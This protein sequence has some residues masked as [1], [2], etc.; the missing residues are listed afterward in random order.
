MPVPD[1]L[2]TA[3]AS[4]LDPDSHRPAPCS[5][6]HAWQRRS[7]LKETDV[8]AWCKPMSNRAFSAHWASHMST[9]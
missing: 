9:S 1:D 2:V 5:R 3:S 7:G 4:G 8:A 6:C